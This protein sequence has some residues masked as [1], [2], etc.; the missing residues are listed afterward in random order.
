M[1]RKEIKFNAEELVSSVE[2]LARH[3]AGDE[4]L[5]LRTKTLALPRPAKP[6]LARWRSFTP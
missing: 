4:K 2:A 3:A 1:K 5:T 6:N